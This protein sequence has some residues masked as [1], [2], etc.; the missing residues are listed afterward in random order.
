[1]NF[2][3]CKFGYWSDILSYLLLPR[4]FYLPKVI[5]KY[6]EHNYLDGDVHKLAMRGKINKEYIVTY[7]EP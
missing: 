7:N 5:S 4:D 1:M 2:A 6:I 3:L